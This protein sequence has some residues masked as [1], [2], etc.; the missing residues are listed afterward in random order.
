M[1]LGFRVIHFYLEFLGFS[2]F[3]HCLP[4]VPI[5]RIEHVFSV[6][7]FNSYIFLG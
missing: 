3:S 5:G 2:I 4:S 7:T 6:F 1:D